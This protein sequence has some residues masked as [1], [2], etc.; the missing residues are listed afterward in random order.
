MCS[1]STATSWAHACC[2]RWVVVLREG[3]GARAKAAGCLLAG[4]RAC[5]CVRSATETMLR[6]LQLG[7]PLSWLVGAIA[8]CS[9]HVCS[10]P[11]PYLSLLMCHTGGPGPE[12]AGA[13]AWW[14]Q[15]GL[16]RRAV[17]PHGRVSNA[18]HAGGGVQQWA[19]QL[20]RRSEKDRQCVCYD[21]MCWFVAARTQQTCVDAPCCFSLLPHVFTPS[22]PFLLP[23]RS[24]LAWPR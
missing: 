1:L 24:C 14:P 10:A 15:A 17:Q 8:R 13:A 23:C 3:C 5:V 22:R 19:A 4:L 11:C 6:L 21:T 18:L 2:S 12:P 16:Q 20:W 9:L 7:W